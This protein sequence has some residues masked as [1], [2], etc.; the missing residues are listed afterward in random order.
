MAIFKNFF[1]EG[2]QNTRYQSDEAVIEHQWLHSE[3]VQEEG[4]Q[5]SCK[6]DDTQNFPQTHPGGNR[7]WRSDVQQEGRNHSPYQYQTV[8]ILPVWR[9]KLGIGVRDLLRINR[10]FCPINNYLNRRKL[11]FSTQTDAKEHLSSTSQFG[12]N[13]R[14]I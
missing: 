7:G 9:I 8:E 13:S 14:W 4:R 11:C 5:I 6:E 12:G 2:N 3:T 1:K 10:S